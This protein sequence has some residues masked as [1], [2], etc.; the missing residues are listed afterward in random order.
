M[1]L[2]GKIWLISQ[3]NHWQALITGKISFK[4]KQLPNPEKKTNKN[5]YIA[6]NGHFGHFRSP[7]RQL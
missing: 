6:K 4:P 3:I 1:K 2:P 7:I 5:G